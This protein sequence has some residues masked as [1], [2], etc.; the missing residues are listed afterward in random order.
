MEIKWDL[1]MNSDG[2]KLETIK[3]NRWGSMTPA[4]EVSSP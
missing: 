4:P 1:G 3:T 2:G